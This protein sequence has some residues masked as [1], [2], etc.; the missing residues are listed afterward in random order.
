M[1]ASVESAG[2]TLGAY[3]WRLF[4]FVCIFW[5]I[6]G[7]EMYVMSLV[8]PELPQSWGLTPAGRGILGG[9]TFIGMLVGAI[10]FGG[11]ADRYGRLFTVRV[12][13]AI[14]AIF[15]CLCAVADSTAMLFVLRTL[16]GFGVGGCIPS[17]IALMVE[18]SP[19]DT[20]GTSIG[21]TLC[22]FA[23]GGMFVTAMSIFVLPTMGWAWMLFLAACPLLL[24]VPFYWP[25]FI[26][27]SPKWLAA[28]GVAGVASIVVAA[29]SPREARAIS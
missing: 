20:A 23:I 10:L 15:G 6:D 7:S 4:F 26:H 22:F 21:V 11:V 14:S 16:F 27:E 13:L 19:S 29:C 5:G 17:I 24:C 8:L 25:D 3:Q 18:S 12:T 28:S 2:G 9:S 1:A